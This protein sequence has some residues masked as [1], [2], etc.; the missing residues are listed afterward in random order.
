MTKSKLAPVNEVLE[1]ITEI[2]NLN[3]SNKVKRILLREE[4]ELTESS[5]DEL[6]PRE[7]LHADY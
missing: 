4:C 1:K 3:T 6:C 5:I 7:P 2:L